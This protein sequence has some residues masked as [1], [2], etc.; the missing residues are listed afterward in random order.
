MRVG[1]AL[2]PG[3][4]QRLLLRYWVVKTSLRR[5]SFCAGLHLRIV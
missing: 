1:E 2:G 4:F 5:V 3:D